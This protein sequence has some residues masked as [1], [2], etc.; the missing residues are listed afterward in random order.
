[1]RKKGE[2][3]GKRNRMGN[4]W[5][6]RNF[7]TEKCQRERKG[8]T[9]EGPWKIEWVWRTGQVRSQHPSAQWNLRAPDEAVLKIVGKKIHQKNI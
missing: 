8:K 9:G 2:K 4:Y 6:K 7:L 1:M 5:L 3:R